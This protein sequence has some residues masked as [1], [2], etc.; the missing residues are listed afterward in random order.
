[1]TTPTRTPMKRRSPPSDNGT[2]PPH[3]YG[4]TLLRHHA[5]LLADSSITP[6]P[7]ASAAIAP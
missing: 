5:Q 1:M 2:G 7:R 6:R 4:P 3:A